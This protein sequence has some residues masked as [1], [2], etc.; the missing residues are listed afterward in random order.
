MDGLSSSIMK[1][2]ELCTDFCNMKE[3]EE[4][5]LCMNSCMKYCLSSKTD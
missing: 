5:E 3:D 2:E 4:L 1:C